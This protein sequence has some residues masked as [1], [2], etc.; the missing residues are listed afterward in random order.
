MRK[1]L[2]VGVLIASLSLLSLPH[3]SVEAQPPASTL[4]LNDALTRLD[5]DPAKRGP[6]IIVAP[7]KIRLATNQE[8]G[9]PFSPPDSGTNGYPVNSLA[10]PFDLRLIPCGSVFALAPATM[11]TLATRLPDP[12]PYSDMLPG[13][14]MKLFRASLTPDQLRKLISPGGIGIEDMSREQRPLFLA[15]LPNGQRVVRT[16]GD[17]DAPRTPPIEITATQRA[18]IRLSIRKQLDWFFTDDKSSTMMEFGG[19]D[20]PPGSVRLVLL[21]Q[22]GGSSSPDN[23]FGVS[24]REKQRTRL[25][26]S[27]LPLEWSGLDP[28]VSLTGAQ[29]VGELIQRVRT[30]TRVELYC[31]PRYAELNVY[32]RGRSARAGDILTALCYGI[33]GT[34]RKV[35][36]A[37]IMTND[38]EGYATRL[39]RIRNWATIGS[40]AIVRL[41]HE[42]EARMK[43]QPP[44]A[45]AW[46]AD[47]PNYPD[48]NFQKLIAEQVEARRAMGLGVPLSKVP[49]TLVSDLPPSIQDQV[50]QQLEALSNARPIPGL[51]S[52]PILRSDAIIISP[53]IKTFLVIPGIGPVEAGDFDK[54]TPL[55]RPRDWSNPP[56]PEDSG[57]LPDTLAYRALMIAPSNPAE[58]KV[59]I[60]A[61]QSRGYKKVWVAV[62]PTDQPLLEAAIQEGQREGV[63][64]GALV[65]VL[66]AGSDTTLPLDLNALQE[67]SL[68]LA[69]RRLAHPSLLSLLPKFDT[70]AEEKRL[71]SG[72]ARY[73]EEKRWGSWVRCDSTEIRAHLVARIAALA[74]TSGL[75]GLALTD[76]T[77]PGSSPSQANLAQIFEDDSG[78]GY[79][80]EMRLAFLRQAGIDP[81][82]FGPGDR[83]PLIQPSVPRLSLLYFEDYGLT[84]QYS[85]RVS[86]QNGTNTADLGAKNA[87]EKWL[88]FRV[89][90]GNTHTAA[91]IRELRA[92]VLDA[93]LWS[94]NMGLADVEY[95]ACWLAQMKPGE[96]GISPL[97]TTLLS[98]QE[99]SSRRLRT[100][101]HPLDQARIGAD[102]PSLLI[103]FEQSEQADHNAFLTRTYRSGATA[104]RENWESITLDLRELAP[105]TIPDLLDQIRYAPRKPEQVRAPSGS[106]PIVPQT[107]RPRKP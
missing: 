3:I 25:K 89:A 16:T 26:P 61:A 67:N 85:N 106:V 12:D 68:Q 101:T 64:I 84:G 4:L 18:G 102:N 82:D 52:R 33:T 57:N 13:D 36:P 46:D 74:R 72:Q 45:V 99:D 94:C 31:D 91:F 2:T 40:E 86:I 14:R 90:T 60:R 97:L 54:V 77:A 38:R 76:L 53:K 87:G 49:M 71:A 28:Q 65:R 11:V 104:Y 96:E 73:M 105:A 93:T 55:V 6:L 80:E 92:A 95:S 20:T 10:A 35:G 27:D 43:Q 34:F 48:A 59:L 75:N 78:F 9:S 83:L 63:Q 30:A 21:Q 98:Q 23:L 70:A 79:S 5:W 8:T 69:N 7:D 62:L 51:V 19:L 42:T 24:L 17:P 29:T 39:L 50:K 100:L 22:R 44:I 32:L 47:D 15:L 1:L 103:S 58:A 88:E 41:L 107:P 66:R 37:Y 81:L 56:L